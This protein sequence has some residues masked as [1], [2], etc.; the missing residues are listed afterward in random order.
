MEKD[1]FFLTLG[2][3]PGQT[4]I[5]I[6]PKAQKKNSGHVQPPRCRIKDLKKGSPTGAP[7]PRTDSREPH[8]L[9]DRNR[10]SVM[11]LAAI[12]HPTINCWDA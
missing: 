3:L 2:S 12:K 10:G 7:D 11:G 4:V 9:P 5:D 6:P 8:H 1:T